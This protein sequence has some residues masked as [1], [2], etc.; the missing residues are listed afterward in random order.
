MFVLERSFALFVKGTE[1][2]SQCVMRILLTRELFYITLLQ[3]IGKIS[4][5]EKIQRKISK[6]K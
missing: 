1:W 6:T 2:N 4:H 5:I 3:T